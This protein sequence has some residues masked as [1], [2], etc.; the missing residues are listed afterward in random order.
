MAVILRPARMVWILTK[1]LLS[2]LR[3][4]YIFTVLSFVFAVS[5]RLIILRSISTCG[6]NSFLGFNNLKKRLCGA[7]FAPL[8]EA[9]CWERA[10][11]VA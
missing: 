2:T 11:L 6:C 4:M 3:A 5:T 8:H 10:S 9:R 1:L 7:F